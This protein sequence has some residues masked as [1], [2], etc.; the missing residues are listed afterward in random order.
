MIM[1]NHQIFSTDNKTDISS[2]SIISLYNTHVFGHYKNVLLKEDKDLNCI[3]LTLNGNAHI[4]TN[5]GSNVI[6]S[7]NSIY[8]GKLSLIHSLL[9]ECKHWHFICCW[10]IPYNVKLP[11]NKVF[12]LNE[13][14]SQQ[15]DN[16]FNKIIRLLQMNSLLK[17]KYANSFFYCKLIEYIEQIDT[18]SSQKSTANVDKI[19]Q[20]I[21]ENIDKPLK[22]KDI[23]KT[24]HY[25][26]KH[27]R[28]LFNSTLKISPKQYITNLKLENVRYNIITTNVSIQELADKYNFSSL[29]HLT[30]SFKKKYGVSPTK[31]KRNKYKKNTS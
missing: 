27:I 15:T 1:Q 3:I 7:E 29:N 11:Q 12:I 30:N 13:I 23:A 22:I 6:L 10:F 4:N 25:C 31:Y 20:Y 26:E 9:S 17:T 18:S 8:F 19:I 16:D 2:V 24:F 21:N 28:Y 5:N 14:N